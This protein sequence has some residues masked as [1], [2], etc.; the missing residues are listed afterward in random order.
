[1]TINPD[2]ARQMLGVLDDEFTRI[3]A[4][5]GC[6]A[7]ERVI[8]V[9][10]SAD[11]YRQSTNVP[12]WSGGLFDGRIK[13]PVF[14]KRGFTPDLR[15]T[16]AHEMSHACLGL[17]GNWPLWLNEGIAQKVSGATIPP[18]VRQQLHE[19]GRQG[20]LPKLSQLGQSWGSLNAD[21]AR[22]AYALSLEAVEVFTRDFSAL[23][24]LRSPERLPEITEALDKRLAE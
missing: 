23:G 10:Q 4:E 22:V 24:L 13:V 1:L 3:S 16:L 5:L 20:K 17:L 15:E 2:V 12:E 9:A 6:T 7:Q 18:A 21:Q 8:A 11:A 14:D 19:L